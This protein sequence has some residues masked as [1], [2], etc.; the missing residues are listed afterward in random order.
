MHWSDH[1]E[2][3]DAL[4][5]EYALATLQG[6]AR[7]RFEAVMARRP[8][9]RDA[10]ARWEQQVGRLGSV[11]PPVAPSPGLWDSLAARTGGAGAAAPAASE[12][13][14][15]TTSR[16]AAS[17]AAAAEPGPTAQPVAPRR[18]APPGLLQRLA[19]AF[20]ALLA[21][22]PAAALAF[23]LVAGLALPAVM[24]ALS[25]PAAQDTELPES[26]VGVLA[27]PDGRQGLIVASRRRGRVVDLK[28]VTPVTPPE[29]QTLFLWTIDA[30]AQVAPVGP[31]PH[32]A[33]VQAPLPAPAEQVFSTAVELAVSIEPV[34]T[35]PAAPSGD[36]V[37]RGLCG[38]VWRVPGAGS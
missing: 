2:A 17:P 4:A 32:G 35:R 25:P 13:A 28:Q 20:D 9:L 19:R 26:Y 27:T 6:P 33:F 14:A 38:K 23:G 15:E 3:V 30:N 5:A 18:G 11:L 7:R 29:G 12:S 16:V 31:V 34:G 37:Y 10:V 36:F 1:P 24:T 22:A 8:A 21:P